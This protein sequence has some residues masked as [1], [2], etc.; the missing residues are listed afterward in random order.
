MLRAQYTPRKTL[1]IDPT[2]V[3]QS[4]QYSD[5]LNGT[6]TR[7][8]DFV[9]SATITIGT[10]AAAAILN[11]GSLLA[12]VNSMGVEENGTDRIVIDGRVARFYAEVSSPSALTAQRL[13]S[14]AV[15]ATQLRELVRVYFAHPFSINPME[16]AYVEQNVLAKLQ[17]FVLLAESSA[18]KIAT[19]GGGGGTVVLSNVTVTVAQKHDRFMAPVK[20]L[21]VPF[22]KQYVDTVVGADALHTIPIKTPRYIRFMFISQ[23]TSTS[24]EVNDIVNS[25]A[26]RGDARDIIGP[27]MQAMQDLDNAMEAEYGGAVYAT[28]NHAHLA[29]QFAENGRLTGCINPLQDTNLRIEANVQPSASAGSSLIRITTLEL[30]RVA[31]LTADKIPFGI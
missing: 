24:G 18:T 4:R 15:G 5:L 12:A 1:V 17:A 29:L 28:A 27:T 26:L 23:E 13:T 19:P 9:L 31:G 2:V 21:F 30:E 11:R 22:I 7:W 20:P 16:T 3:G 8:I 25:L 6:Q 14:T 10:A